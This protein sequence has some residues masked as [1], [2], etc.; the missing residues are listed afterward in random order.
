MTFEDLSL[1]FKTARPLVLLRAKN[2]PFMLSFFYKV[3]RES[4]LT[5]ITNTELRNKLEGYM[6]DLEYEEKDEELEAATLF[7]DYSQKATQYIDKWSNAG[8]LQKYPDDEGEDLHELTS[9]TIKVFEWIEN[10]QRPDHIGT[11]S[12]FRDI[13]FKL[14]GMIEQSTENSELRIQEL[15]NKKWE[16]ENEINL[17]KQGKK[18][19]TY[20]DTEIKEEFYNLNKMARELLSDF[21][22]VEQ[23]FE[24]IR[25]EVQRKYNE[26]DIA[27]GSLLVF[28]LDALDEIENKDQGKS[29]KAFWEFLMDEK[30]QQEFSQLT[31]KLYQLLKER[32]IDFN[33]DRFLKNLKRFLHAS[34]KKVI[35]SNRKLSEKISRVLS[36][37]NLLE[38]RRAME[39]IGEIRQMAFTLTDS[40]IKEEAFLVI[41]DEPD[42]NLIDRWELNDG[43][44]DILDTLFPDGI[45]GAM[46][47]DV[48]LKSLFDQFTI[49]RKKLQKNIDSML[50]DRIQVTLK[51]IVDNYGLENGLSEIVGYFSIAS[52][53]DHHIILEETIEPIWIKERKL[54][55][56]MI[57]YTKPVK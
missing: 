2:A 55:I 9:D 3:F 5:T 35:D 41:E 34:G 11:N 53:N 38:R 8:Y 36:E 51:E 20:D 26:K 4:H 22:E 47:D 54:N 12:R 6:E 56:P 40:R 14:R 15:E 42:I 1:Q 7:D 33:N 28:A 23:N 43:R 25:K 19:V 30:K 45:G 49:D 32:D 27:K 52:S 37:K 17:I 44:E 21:A 24:Q 39:L 48:D 46:S 10:L 18:P 57:L 29:F 50:S 31:E 13:F 16:I